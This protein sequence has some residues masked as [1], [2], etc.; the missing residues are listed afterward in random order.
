MLLVAL[1]PKFLMPSI[2]NRGDISYGVY[3]YAFPVQ[4]AIIYFIPQIS[5][6]NTFLF[7]LLPT[8]ALAILSW[9]YIESPSLKLKGKILS[10]WGKRLC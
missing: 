7:S 8:I 4:Q 9:N 2:D 5:P 3:I 10:G 1:N 6:L